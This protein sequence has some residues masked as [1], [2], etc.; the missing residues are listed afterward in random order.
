LDPES[1]ICQSIDLPITQSNIESGVRNNYSAVA[2]D[3]CRNEVTDIACNALPVDIKKARNG[4]T[5]VTNKAMEDYT[6]VTKK[7]RNVRDDYT[8]VTNTRDDYTVVTNKARDDYTVVTN[9]RDDYTVVTNKARD[10]YTVVTNTRD[11]YT[12]VTHQR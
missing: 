2:A 3:K 4:C 11:D 10:D 6:A 12:V 7:A 1:I 8:V 9:T 5:V